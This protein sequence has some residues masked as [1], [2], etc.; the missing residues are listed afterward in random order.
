MINVSSRDSFTAF[1]KY[2]GRIQTVGKVQLS[3]TLV[4]VERLEYAL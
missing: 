3:E 4:I 1:D 2:D